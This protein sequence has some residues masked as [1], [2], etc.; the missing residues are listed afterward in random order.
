MSVCELTGTLWFFAVLVLVRKGSPVPSRPVH[1]PRNRSP[2]QR[3]PSRAE[4]AG[5]P[6]VPP[7]GVQRES[8]REH[9]HLPQTG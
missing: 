2:W 4:A 6:A 1:A 3:L 5:L 8:Q 7:G 9:H